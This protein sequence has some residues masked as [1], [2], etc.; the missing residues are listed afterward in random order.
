MAR[1]LNRHISIA[2]SFGGMCAGALS[3]LADLFGMTRAPLM[4]L[5]ICCLL[6]QVLLAQDMAFWLLS[7]LCTDM[8]ENDT[9][10]AMFEPRPI[11]HCVTTYCTLYKP[12]SVY[13][14]A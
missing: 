6:L 1:E 7:H 2:A 9:Y 11:W 10:V 5:L 4:L 3:V 12:V 13:I 8:L 14:C